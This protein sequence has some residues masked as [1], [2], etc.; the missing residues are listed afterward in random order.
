MSETPDRDAALTRDELLELAA[1]DALGAL[2]EL[3]RHISELTQ[4]AL[5]ALET[6][7][8]VETAKV[9]LAALADYVS[10]RSV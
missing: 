6:A 2:D 8:I 1:A 3:E 4:A 7:P 10:W 5:A 9:E